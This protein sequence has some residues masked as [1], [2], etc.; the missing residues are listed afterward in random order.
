MEIVIATV[1]DISSLLHKRISASVNKT[2]FV[3]L[4]LFSFTP[5]VVAAYLFFS[6]TSISTVYISYISIE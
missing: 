6:K 1:K 5:A 4:L 3:C 2:E